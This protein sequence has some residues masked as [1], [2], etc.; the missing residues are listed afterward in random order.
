MWSVRRGAVTVGLDGQVLG[1]F[2]RSGG[3]LGEFAT[4]WAV[5]VNDAGRIIVA[6]TGNPAAD[7]VNP[8]IARRLVLRC[9]RRHETG[10][11]QAISFV[12]FLAVFGGILPVL[13]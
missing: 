10:A 5:A 9:G 3:G 2:G 11:V 12:V 1:R 4:P 7:G 8:M 13:E 6:D